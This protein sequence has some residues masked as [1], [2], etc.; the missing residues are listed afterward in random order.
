LRSQILVII[1]AVKFRGLWLDG[2]FD[3]TQL[4]NQYQID[5]SVRPEPNGELSCISQW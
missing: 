5:W 3:A 4:I 1:L 2:K